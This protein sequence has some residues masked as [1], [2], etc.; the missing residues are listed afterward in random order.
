MNGNILILKLICHTKFIQQ[1]KRRKK[2]DHN[3]IKYYYYFV[4]N[5][6]NFLKLTAFTNEKDVEN[7]KNYDNVI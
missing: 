5:L 3:K 1:N 6:D 7:T 2:K 4:L